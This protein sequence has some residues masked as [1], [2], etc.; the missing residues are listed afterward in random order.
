VGVAGES[1]FTDVPDPDAGPRPTPVTYEQ[2]L[3]SV[4]AFA[5]GLRSRP[6]WVQL[7]VRAVGAL[8]AVIALVAIVW[9]LFA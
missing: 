7:T 1:P 9:M 5:A 3:A 2:Q 6:A 4:G 8:F